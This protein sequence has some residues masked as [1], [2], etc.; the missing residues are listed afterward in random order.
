[1]YGTISIGRLY[2]ESLKKFQNYEYFRHKRKI[3]ITIL[4]MVAV[5]FDV[6]QIFFEY[7][8]FY[9][10]FFDAIKYKLDFHSMS[11]FCEET[12]EIALE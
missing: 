2:L 12:F 7:S 10:C 9:A 4:I 8:F 1:M 5:C 3:K 6:L 11:G